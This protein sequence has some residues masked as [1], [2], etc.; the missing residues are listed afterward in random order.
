MAKGF[1]GRRCPVA[2][3]GQPALSPR[4][5]NPAAPF[6][7]MPPTPSGGQRGGEPLVPLPKAA[8]ADMAT[9]APGVEAT[10]SWSCWGHIHL[11]GLNTHS[12]SQ[13]SIIM[14]S[15]VWT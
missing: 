5:A 6:S 11:P 15:L 12:V 1:V 13:S 14:L 3:L 2:S 10:L 7:T 9:G 4:P 8:D